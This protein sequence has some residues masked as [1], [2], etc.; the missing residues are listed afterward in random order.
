MEWFYHS[1]KVVFIINVK[2]K[3]NQSMVWHLIL[4]IELFHWKLLRWQELKWFLKIQIM[5]V[6]LFKSTIIF[7]RIYRMCL[8]TTGCQHYNCISNDKV[9][10]PNVKVLFITRVVRLLFICTPTLPMYRLWTQ[11]QEAKVGIRT[12][13]SHN[14]LLFFTVMLQL[15]MYVMFLSEGQ[16]VFIGAVYFHSPRVIYV[17]QALNNHLC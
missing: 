17:E 1:V 11:E 3:I 2:V 9:N 13:N 5:M 14:F 10:T 12:I 4:I 8:V 6:I 16:T 15:P 7:N